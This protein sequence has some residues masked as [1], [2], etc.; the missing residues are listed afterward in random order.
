MTLKNLDA[1]V[2]KIVS[3]AL[4]EKVFSH[5]KYTAK[6][7]RTHAIM[8]FRKVGV[9]PEKAAAYVGMSELRVSC[10]YMAPLSAEDCPANLTNYRLRT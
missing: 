10:Y 2:E 4:P 3:A 5:R 6:D 7:M 9:A 8:E 1:A